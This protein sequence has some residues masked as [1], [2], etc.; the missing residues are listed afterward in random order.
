MNKW[1]NKKMKMKLFIGA[2]AVCSLVPAASCSIKSNLPVN[3][4]R[5]TVVQ[6]T[7][8]EQTTLNEVMT[9]E[10]TSEFVRLDD[11][12]Y[13]CFDNALFLGSSRVETLAE[14]GLAPNADNFAKVGINI[15]TIYDKSPDGGA[16]IYEK[17]GYGSY[18]RI[19]LVFGDNECAWPYL[20]VFED[21]YIELINNLS[22]KQ[23]NAKIYIQSVLPISKKAN[24]DE[25]NIKDGYTQENIDKIN[26]VIKDVAEKTDSF[27]L[28]A[29]EEFTADD[30]FMPE[31][32]ASDG[33][34]F[35]KKYCLIW[36][37]YLAKAMEGQQ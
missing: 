22:E 9:G 20:N 14:Y 19:V 23:P 2:L 7:Q 16:S 21:E 12:A 29:P 17:I 26:E 34:H 11:G 8:A 24:E 37:E 15:R 27:Y 3:V 35:G 10:D 33:V 32:A 28:P 5:T 4:E 30:G 18:D 1:V 31:N 6:M 25:V 36:L 13:P